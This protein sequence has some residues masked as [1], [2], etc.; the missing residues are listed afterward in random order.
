[1]TIEISSF[2]TSKTLS[3]CSVYLNGNVFAIIGEKGTDVSYILSNPLRYPPMPNKGKHM[4]NG[5]F[6]C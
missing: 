5:N 1:M 2:F 6:G 4:D 3:F